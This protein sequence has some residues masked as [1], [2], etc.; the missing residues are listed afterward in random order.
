V[1]TQFRIALRL[2]RFEVFAAILAAGVLAASAFIVRSRLDAIGVPMSCWDAWFSSAGLA[3]P[4]ACN[5]FADQFLSINEYEGGKVMASMALLPLALGLFLGV[6]LVARE[7]EGGTAP[8][9]WTLAASRVRWFGGRLLP[10]LLI[11]V[12]M[13]AVL[14]VASDV[15]WAGREPWGPTPRFGD[16]GLHG[17]I[18]FGKG[19]AAFGIAVLLGAIFGRIL[20]S[21]IVG[22]LLGV[23]LYVGWGAG[24][25]L[26]L[27]AEGAN[28]RV[29]V[30]GDPGSV[31]TDEIFPGGWGVVNVVQ[32]PDGRFV[33]PWEVEGL[34]PAGTEDT[35][36]WVFETYPAFIQG[37]PAEQ[38]GTWSA[39]ETTTFSLIGIGALLLAFPVVARRRPM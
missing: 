32:L 29:A 14:A 23:A 10:I 6:P 15:L 8:T 35:Y 24:F 34:A 21:V 38:Y 16:A 18:I 1:I 28:H 13:M 39:T 25:D 2:Q 37:V 26:W 31:N 3:I 27:Q 17:P 30:V 4:P 11:V 7:I 12:V 33:Q 36:T 9:V 22:A 5:G 20:P 19:L